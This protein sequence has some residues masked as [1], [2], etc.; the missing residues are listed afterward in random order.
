M[1]K[2]YIPIV[3]FCLALVLMLFAHLYGRDLAAPVFG[4]ASEEETEGSP[5]AQPREIYLTFDDGPSTVVTGRILD[6]LLKEGV[7]ATFFITGER[8]FGR[9]EVL[10]RIHDEG[11]AIG[12]HT[13]SHRYDAIYSS[14][15]A[16]LEDVRKCAEIIEKVTGEKPKLYRFPGGGRHDRFEALLREMGYET[17]LWNAVCGDEEIPHADAAT[18]E[19]RAIETAKG[20][21]KVVLLLHDSAPHKATAEALP[22]IIE[23]FRDEGYVFK[24]L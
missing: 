22:K 21:K 7:P 5:K 17:V 23:H 10:R 12:V 2:R 18:L 14:D 11:H 20:K 15:R 19:R 1:Q 4:F 13:Y 16:F 24:S 6:I 9:E 8:V 3:I